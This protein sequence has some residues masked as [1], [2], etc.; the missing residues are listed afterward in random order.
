MYPFFGSYVCTVVLLKG[1][2]PLLQTRAVKNLFKS[3][4]MIEDVNA[5]MV[6][7]ERGDLK[8]R[9]RALEAE[10]ALARVTVSPALS[11]TQQTPFPQK[12]G[13]ARIGKTGQPERCARA[14]WRLS[15]PPS[16]AK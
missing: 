15:V 6:R 2:L 11:Q 9:V 7:L 13:I 14:P 5:T 4:N 12:P 16:G 1:L 8:L 10:R 3:P